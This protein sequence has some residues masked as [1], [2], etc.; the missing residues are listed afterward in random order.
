MS[1]CL[2]AWIGYIHKSNEQGQKSVLKCVGA[3]KPYVLFFSNTKLI[4]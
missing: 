2:D 1:V 4:I 3:K